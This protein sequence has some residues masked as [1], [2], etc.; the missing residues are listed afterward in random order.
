[1]GGELRQPFE[2]GSLAVAWPRV[3]QA[4]T[5]AEVRAGLAAS[6][7]GDPGVETGAELHLALRLGWARRI[8]DA[9]PETRR[10]VS[11][12]LALLLGREILVAGRPPDLLPLAQARLRPT[13]WERATTLPELVA[14][15]PGE[16]AWAFEGVEQATEL[17]RAE[18][19]WWDKVESEAER[20]VRRS[21]PGREVVIGAVTLLAADARRVIGALEAA[22]RGA[23]D[24]FG[25]VI[26]AGP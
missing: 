14:S 2:L 15:L 26:G 5:A 10:W 19:R 17:W 13:G 24:T 11:A 22:A 8:L 21:R 23:A 3:A 4:Q 1:M 9:A 12:A 7:W 6:A 20:M 18:A 25:E 16:A